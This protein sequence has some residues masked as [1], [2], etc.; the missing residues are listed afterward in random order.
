MFLKVS[1]V[2]GPAH[3]DFFC[4][5]IKLRRMPVHEFRLF[6]CLQCLCSKPERRV[7][8][9]AAIDVEKERLAAVRVREDSSLAQAAAEISGQQ[10]PSIASLEELLRRPHVHYP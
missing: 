4:I 6:I 5:P 3:L 8:E 9:Q 10:V 1:G 7:S 2:M